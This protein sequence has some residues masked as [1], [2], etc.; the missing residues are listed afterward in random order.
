MPL[1]ELSLAMCDYDHVRS[2]V[3]GSVTVEGAT[4]NVQRFQY[5]SQIFHRSL[6][7]EEWDI[8]EMSFAKYC[9]LIA[10]GDDRFRAIPVFPSRCFRHSAVYVAASS[11]R[12]DLSQLR[13]C[14][15]GIPEWSQTAGVYVR[16][17][18]VRDYAVDLSTIK[19]YQGGVRRLGR[20]EIVSSRLPPEVDVTAVTDRPL[21]IM[22]D[23]GELDAIIA[24][25]GPSSDGEPAKYRRLVPDVHQVEKGYWERTGI[26]PIMHVVAIR[27]AT[28][29][30]HPWLARNLRMAFDAARDDSLRRLQV[31]HA[32]LYPLPFL[33][34]A[35]AQAEASMG[36]NF[37]PYGLDAN[38]TTIDAFL[39]YAHEQG[40]SER[41]LDAEELFIPSAVDEFRN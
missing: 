16:G 19:W 27:R 40:V 5:P 25:S 34:Y 17:T 10:A 35:L 14:R 8:S 29:E 22:L 4:L 9:S 12:D 1:A 37:W 6:G 31:A 41:R 28:C 26:F 18:L 3:D 11:H 36:P 20:S 24:A 21:Q 38:R 15:V 30:R 2:L 23:E 32:S 7:F 39:E 33:P 13:G